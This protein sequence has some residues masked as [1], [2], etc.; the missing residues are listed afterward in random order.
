M[1]CVSSIGS[2][3]HVRILVFTNIYFFGIVPAETVMYR[4]FYFNNKSGN[5]RLTL[6]ELKRGNLIAAIQHAD[7]E[8]DINKVLRFVC[9][10]IHIHDYVYCLVTILITNIYCSSTNE[11]NCKLRFSIQM[12]SQPFFLYVVTILRYLNLSP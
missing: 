12:H 10:C 8:E 2:G 4:I 6:R 5:G 11:R 3:L 7:V 9:S 1:V